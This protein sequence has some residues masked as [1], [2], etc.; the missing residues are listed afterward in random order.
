[1]VPPMSAP[2]LPNVIGSHTTGWA[3]TMRARDES[4]TVVWL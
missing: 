3:R 4:Y 2:I 1:M